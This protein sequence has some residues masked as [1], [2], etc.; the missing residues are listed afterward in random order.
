MGLFVKLDLGKF[1]SLETI[2]LWLNDWHERKKD[3]SYR[4]SAE[5]EALV[6][7]N[8]ARQLEMEIVRTKAIEGRVKV[9][10]DLGVPKSKIRKA[11]T[12]HFF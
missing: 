3:K 9:L 5:A 4:N 1:N 10:K 2:R 6:I 12:T 8:L 7:A 11:I